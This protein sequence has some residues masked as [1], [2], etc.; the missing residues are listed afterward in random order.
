MID[1]IVFILVANTFGY[2]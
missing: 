2:R 1:E